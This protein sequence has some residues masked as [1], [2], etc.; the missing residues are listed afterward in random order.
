M[1][2]E[3]EEENSEIKL[4]LQSVKVYRN[5]TDIN[6]EMGE[7][8]PNVGG[9]MESGF[10]MFD[11]FSSESSI[12]TKKAIGL[13]ELDDLFGIKSNHPLN[14]KQ[15]FSVFNTTGDQ[16]LE[17]NQSPFDTDIFGT[18][19]TL[20]T[21][22]KNLV[23]MNANLFGNSSV[24][25]PISSIEKPVYSNKDLKITCQVTRESSTQMSINYSCS[26]LS[27]F[28]LTNVKLTFL[29]PKSVTVKVNSTSGFTLDPNQINGIKKELSISN[30]S[31]KQV[32]LKLK[33]SY[34]SNGQEMNESITLS[35]F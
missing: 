9:K 8:N 20:K 23:E 3:D 1:I 22:N 30:D 18:V 29:A 33:I 2:D 31:S 34:N 5:M 14:A 7:F 6:K 15:G 19:N 24:E 27:S 10:T 17:G 16:P 28:S 12:S 11:P 13:S 32:V 21:T 25:Q 4:N 35:E 26:N